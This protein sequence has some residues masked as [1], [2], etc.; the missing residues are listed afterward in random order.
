MHVNISHL[1]HPEVNPEAQIH[2]RHPQENDEMNQEPRRQNH[3]E[4]ILW[5]LIQPICEMRKYRAEMKM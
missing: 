2:R 4:K 1:H 5:M 3:R